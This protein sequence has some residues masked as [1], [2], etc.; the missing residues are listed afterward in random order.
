MNSY[1]AQQDPRF[2]NM[3]PDD[4]YMAATEA[5]DAQP[6][7]P[8]DERLEQLRYEHGRTH[9]LICNLEARLSALLSPLPQK[10]CETAGGTSNPTPPQAPMCAYIED[11]V[12]SIREANARLAHLLNALAI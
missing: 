12:D 8:M 9:D 7:S 11:R 4:Y 5:C 10:D 6:V 1:A 2:A 3:K